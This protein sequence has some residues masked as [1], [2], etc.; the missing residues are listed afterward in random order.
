MA[1]V[2]W[3]PGVIQ[4]AELAYRWVSKNRHLLSRFF[5][6]GEA[7]AILPARERENERITA[8]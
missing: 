7:C 1:L 2:L 3:I 5:G 6:C 4:I 8:E